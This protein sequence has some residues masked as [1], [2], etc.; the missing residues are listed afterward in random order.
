M[1]NSQTLLDYNFHIAQYFATKLHNFTK[2][3]KLFSTVLKLFSNLKV[4]LS[5]EWTI[6]KVNL[7]LTFVKTLTLSMVN[8]RDGLKIHGS[9]YIILTRFSICSSTWQTYS[10]SSS[11]AYPVFAKSTNSNSG[12]ISKCPCRGWL[13]LF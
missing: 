3:R 2:F 1:Q 12:T 8:R 11:H 10:S 6:T 5:G 7:Q 13:K 4:C 9:N